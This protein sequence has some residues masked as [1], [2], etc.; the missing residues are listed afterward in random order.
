MKV[1]GLDHV[2]LEQVARDPGGAAAG[3]LDDFAR[4]FDR[5]LIHFDVDTV[6]FT[7]AP[8]SENT[9]RNEGLSLDSA[10]GALAPLLSSARLSAVTIT[11][12]NPVHGAED[13]ATL[14][15]F[16]AGLVRAF[17]R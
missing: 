8:L 1:R 9:G 17:S 15:R 7:D 2:P 6:D 14:E 13:G 4:R 16:V 10:L 3:V 12:L 5:L 11:E